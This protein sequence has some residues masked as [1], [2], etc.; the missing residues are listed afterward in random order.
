MTPSLATQISINDNVVGSTTANKNLT[1][2]WNL[3]VLGNVNFAH[4]V[5]AV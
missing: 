4:L 3:S 2:T 1:L 5:G